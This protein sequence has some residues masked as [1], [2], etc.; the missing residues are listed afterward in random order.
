MCTTTPARDGY[1]SQGAAKKLFPQYKIQH[2]FHIL[3][4][5]KS[6]NFVEWSS[7]SDST[8]VEMRTAFLLALTTGSQELLDIYDPVR[9]PA[10]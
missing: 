8:T 7:E 4:G 1:F 2:L 6:G 10:K 3:R 9:P 5:V